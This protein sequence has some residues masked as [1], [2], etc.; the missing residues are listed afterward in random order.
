MVEE[1]SKAER[2]CAG[3]EPKSAKTSE[4]KA[5]KS[6]PVVSSGKQQIGNKQG[7]K[8]SIEATSV[9]K[10]VAEKKAKP[11][12]ITSKRKYSSAFLN[13]VEEEMD[14]TYE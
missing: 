12:A 13:H 9:A 4:K 7:P 14:W 6:R 1:D 3:I 10:A 5:S 11:N 8:L 2:K